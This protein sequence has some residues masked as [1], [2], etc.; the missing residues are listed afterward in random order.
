M[1]KAEKMI[2]VK[3]IKDNSEAVRSYAGPKSSAW[4]RAVR[5][6]ELAR[7]LERECK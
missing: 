1:T 7:K 6:A 4:R 3:L 5:M 2:L